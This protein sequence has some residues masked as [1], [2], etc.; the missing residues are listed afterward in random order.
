MYSN[1][2]KVYWAIL[3]VVALVL[4]VIA[5]SCGQTG[6]SQ[7]GADTVALEKEVASLQNELDELRERVAVPETA[8]DEVAANNREQTLS[9]SHEYFPTTPGHYALYSMSDGYNELDNCSVEVVFQ[10]AEQGKFFTTLTK[11]GTTGG[12]FRESAI[13][14]RQDNE[15][16]IYYAGYPAGNQANFWYRLLVL[17]LDLID[18]GTWQKGSISYQSKFVGDIQVGSTTYE[19]CFKIEIDNNNSIEEFFRGEGEV[20]LSRGI[21]IVEYVFRRTNGETFTAQIMEHGDYLPTAVSGTLTLDGE[22]SAE[23]YMV[24]IAN[25]SF[26]SLSA[27]V[28]PSD[29]SFALELFGRSLLLRYGPRYSET[30]LD[31]GESKEYRL[32]DL[33]G[34]IAGLDLSMGLLPAP[35]QGSEPV[36]ELPADIHQRAWNQA[37]TNSQTDNYFKYSIYSSR[38]LAVS[39]P[40]VYLQADELWM[41]MISESGGWGAN[42]L[43]RDRELTSATGWWE[44]VGGKINDGFRNGDASESFQWSEFN[45]DEHRSNA[46]DLFDFYG[47]APTLDWLDSRLPFL[48]NSM[49][50]IGWKMPRVSLA[51]A[52]YMELLSE[53]SQPYLLVTEDKQAYVADWSGNDVT[54]LD[55]QTGATLWSPAGEPVLVMNSE[56]VWY[57][58]MDRDDR[59]KDAGLRAVVTAYGQENAM[60]EMTQFE[61]SVL[62]DLKNGTLLTTVDEFSWAKLVAIRAVNQYT[63]RSETLRELSA[64]LFPERYQEDSGYSDSPYELQCLG[65]VITEM[66]NRLSPTAALWA[67]TVQENAFE[68]RAAFT[69]LG[70]LYWERFQRTDSDSDWVYGDFYHGWFPTLDDKLIS[71]LGNCIVEATGTA[72]ALSL[73][74]VNGWEVYVTNWWS[75]EQSGGHVISGA[76]T[77]YGNYSLSNGLFQTRDQSVLNGPLW[78]ANGVVAYVMIYAPEKGFI[79]T[80]QTKNA[81]NYSPFSTP[82]T[83]MDFSGAVEFLEHIEALEE[84]TTVVVGASPTVASTYR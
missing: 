14:G 2:K 22:R 46:V 62:T 13:G 5:I 75:V 31:V 36:V 15:R 55:P 35:P 42:Y 4:V 84:Q 67:P 27:A 33:K 65:M 58:L 48:W 52:L 72:A 44:E 71:G 77:P 39:N 69:E 25:G 40:E 1:G 8:V 76:Y 74:S 56:Y 63:W 6:E 49:K 45:W 50:G 26:H 10:H 37:A 38:S 54:L 57:P 19:D 21:G 18:G 60:P 28:I 24:S 7:N 17:P 23:G 29:G 51:E 78:D 9:I 59:A 82:F 47:D 80:T 41:T 68:P 3:A 53:G 61:E 34:N 66:G 83:S 11:I 16:L 81:A 32:N 43:A 73:A 12:Y 64:D 79:V 20:Y 30:V 70:N